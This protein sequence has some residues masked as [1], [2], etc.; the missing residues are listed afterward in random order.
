MLSLCVSPR[1]RSWFYKVFITPWCKLGHEGW[2]GGGGCMGWGSEEERWRVTRPLKIPH[3]PKA[4]CQGNRGEDRYWTSDHF[5]CQLSYRKSFTAADGVKGF[6]AGVW[7]VCFQ[8]KTQHHESPR[9]F[10]SVKAGWLG[11]RV[12]DSHLSNSHYHYRSCWLWGSFGQMDGAFDIW[13]KP[14]AQ[15]VNGRNTRAFVQRSLS[16]PCYALP[17]RFTL[18]FFSHFSSSA[19]MPLSFSCPW[20]LRTTT[21][22]HMPPLYL[23]SPTPLSPLP[24]SLSN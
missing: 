13:K 12:M 4:E 19:C 8:I 24:C 6:G 9:R 3:H 7:Y 21:P 10:L 5:Y 1:I 17:S 11:G 20:S 14:C 22:P 2:L 15:V 23:Y 16:H 18:P